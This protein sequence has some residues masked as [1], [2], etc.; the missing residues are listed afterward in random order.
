MGN[1]VDFTRADELYDEFASV[2]REHDL[3]ADVMIGLCRML[4]LV[5]VTAADDAG[6][7]PD[8]TLDDL[9]KLTMTY[10]PDVGE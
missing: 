8:E 10:I 9:I 7:S 2:P 4:A 3:I 5:V 6:V 1:K